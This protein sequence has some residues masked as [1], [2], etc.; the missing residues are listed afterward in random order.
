MSKL[1]AK[2]CAELRAFLSL[3]CDYSGTQETVRDIAA[4]TLK[5]LKCSARMPDEISLK[6][7]NGEEPATLEDFIFLFYHKISNAIM[8]VVA[9]HG[10]DFEEQL[11]NTNYY[12]IKNMS[13]EE[14][15]AWLSGNIM[16]CK[17]NCPAVC[18][19]YGYGKNVNCQA[20]FKEWLKKEVD[21]ER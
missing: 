20:V 9:T 4:E 7:W 10:D 21:Y 2:D 5:E 17:S 15:A 6:G 11:K 1:N 16:D 3:G 8:N 19:C 14:L 13:V 12:Y 18:V